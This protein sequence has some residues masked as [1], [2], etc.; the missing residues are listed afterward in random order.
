MW[1]CGAVS[2]AR[3]GGGSR[4][5][6]CVALRASDL[7]SD[8]FSRSPIPPRR[9]CAGPMNVFY[10]SWALSPLR[11][12]PEEGVEPTTC[13][14]Q[15]GCAAVAPLGPGRH[16]PQPKKTA[17]RPVQSQIGYRTPPQGSQASFPAHAVVAAE[18][19][20]SQPLHLLE[21]SAPERVAQGQT[22][23]PPRAKLRHRYALRSFDPPPAVW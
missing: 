11:L 18:A 8:G 2:V 3:H 23:I 19:G 5:R 10:H 20:T 17:R 9:L 1:A 13:R 4:I 21:W 12:E 14:L 16:S 7:Q 22:E 15:I 6:T